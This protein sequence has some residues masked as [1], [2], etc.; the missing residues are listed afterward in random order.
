MYNKHISRPCYIPGSRSDRA[1]KQGPCPQGLGSGGRY[2]EVD[3]H[4]QSS[5]VTA[6]LKEI[7]E[8]L[9]GL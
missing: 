9:R 2:I 3:K 1:H 5:V 7:H 4:L 8:T 6:T